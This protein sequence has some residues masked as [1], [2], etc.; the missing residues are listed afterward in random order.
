[1]CFSSLVCGVPFGDPGC[2]PCG[3]RLDSGF[4]FGSG[5]PVVGVGGLY[6]MGAVGPCCPPHLLSY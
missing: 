6:G 3:L 2:L 4:R 5:P 1:M